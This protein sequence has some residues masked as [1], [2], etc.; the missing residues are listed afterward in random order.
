MNNTAQPVQENDLHAYVD[1]QLDSARMAEVE[2]Y[3]AAH[4]AEAERIQTYQ[5]QNNMLH[6]LF[7][8]VAAEPVPLTMHPAARR[9]TFMPVMRYAA[10]ALWMV[11]GGVAGWLIHGE[12][13]AT[14]AYMASLPHQAAIAHVVYTPE[15]LHPVEVGADQEAHLVKWL[16]KRLNADVHAPHLTEAGYQLVGGRLLPGTDGPAAQFMYQDTKGK[17]LTLYVRIQ[18]K[19]MRET[20][21]RFEQEGKVGVFYWVDGPV[22]YALSGELAK[23]DLLSVANVVYHQLNL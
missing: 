6:A 14:P 5:Q 23:P 15:V 1:G 10:V 22:G 16:S 12:D 11:L 3:L 13:T 21:F 8:P 18:V 20:A 2:A 17:R 4:P 7:D 9:R 19:D